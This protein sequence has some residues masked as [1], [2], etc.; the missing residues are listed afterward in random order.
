[1]PLNTP[2]G[3]G[4]FALNFSFLKDCLFDQVGGGGTPQPMPQQM[5]AA[6]TP[7]VE[8]VAQQVTQAFPG[9][10]NVP[11]L[12]VKN[13]DEQQGP[14]PDWLYEQA[15]AVG[16]TEVWDN[17]NRLPEAQRQGK[18]WPWFRSANQ[19]IDKAFWPPKAK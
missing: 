10:T 1:M 7:N 8:A 14:L 18:N 6:P 12:S 17:R 13:I 5:A 15:A 2:E 3:Q 9:T 4:E 16:V 19:N 11:Q